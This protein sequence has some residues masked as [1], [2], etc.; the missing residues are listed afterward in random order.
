MKSYTLEFLKVNL[1][2]FA[3]FNFQHFIVTHAL[4]FLVDESAFSLV[5]VQ[6]GKNL[7]CINHECLQVD[8]KPKASLGKNKC[9][10]NPKATYVFSP[11]APSGDLSA[12]EISGLVF[13]LIGGLLGDFITPWDDLNSSVLVEYKNWEVN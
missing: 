9:L 6:V 7:A 2:Y 12:Q 5:F 10:L 3:H 1:L 11:L 13:I 8:R 4:Y